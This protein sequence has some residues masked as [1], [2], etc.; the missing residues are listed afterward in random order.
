MPRGKQSC[1]AILRRLGAMIKYRLKCDQAHEF[2]SWFRDSAAF[3]TVASAGGLTCP[4]C[5]SSNVGKAMMAPAIG[6]SRGSRAEP[7][8]HEPSPHEPSP[9]EPAEAPAKP[10]SVPMSMPSGAKMREALFALK[11]LVEKN[12]ENVGDRFADE[13]RKIHRGEA[14][15][16][17]IYGDATEA[18]AEALREEGVPVAR[19]P[20]PKHT[21]S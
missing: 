16:R 3:D 5:G 13:A 17:S 20:W 14:E 19:I 11:S 8:P 9:H 12:A 18:E 2:D 10:D 21:D 4:E 1:G 15:E 7:S 6:R